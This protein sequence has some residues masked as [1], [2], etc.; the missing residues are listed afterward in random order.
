MSDEC[1]E[2]IA[3]VKGKYRQRCIGRDKQWPTCHSDKL[4]RL[5]LVERKKGEGYSANEQRGRK[6]K[7]TK[8]T[9]L[10]YGDLF[11]VESGK[12]PVRKVLVEGD[13]GIGKTTFCIAVSEDWANGK[14]FQQFELVLLLPLRI[15]AVASAGILPDLLKLLHSNP[16]LRDSVASY[17]EVEEGGRVLIIADGWDELSESNRQEGS[18]LYQLLFQLFPLI[19]VVVTSRPYASAPLCYLP[20]IDRFV[21]VRGFSEEHIVDYIQSEFASDQEKAGRLLEQLEDNPLIESVCSVPLNCTIVSYLWDT[22]EGALPTTMTQLYKKIIDNIA[23]RNMHKLDSSVLTFDSRDIPNDF[24]KSWWHLCELAFQALEKDQLVFSPKELKAK[25][26][27]LD[28]GIRCF[29][30]LQTVELVGF[31]ISFHF[32]HRTIQEYLAALHLARLEPDKQLEVFR[33]YNTKGFVMVWRFFFG[34]ND[35]NKTPNYIQQFFGCVADEGDDEISL[36]VCHCVFES[37]SVL[38]NNEVTQY[39]LHRDLYRIDF[40]TP[41]TAHDCAAILYV[42]ANISEC[43]DDILIYFSKNCDVKE[44]QIIELLDILASKEGKLQITYLDLSGSRLTVSS[45]QALESAVHRNLLHRLDLLELVISNTDTNVAQLTSLL[46][47][48]S[49]HCPHIG[50]LSFS[51]SNL[52]V[53]GV[54]VIS[55]IWDHST[56][57]LDLSSNHL[58]DE[59]MAILCEHLENVHVPE[60][61]LECNHIHVSG[62]SHLVDTICSGKAAITDELS[63]AGNPLGLEGTKAVGRMLSSSHCKVNDVLLFD[64]ELTTAGGSDSLNLGDTVSCEAVGQQLCQ[65]PQNSAVGYIDLSDNSFTVEGI[66]I[67]AGLMHLCPHISTVHTRNC[68]ITSDDLE[69]LLDRLAQL[70]SSSPSL[71]SK[72]VG[73]F[74][75]DNQIDNSGVSTLLNHLPS[76]FPRLGSV[77]LDNNQVNS[78]LMK[79]LNE[80]CRRRKEVSNSVLLVLISIEHENN[81]EPHCA[82]CRHS[83]T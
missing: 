36:S 35:F 73:W 22:L 53:P 23:L 3:S 49:V 37:H 63:L 40:G 47:T 71:C 14:L 62:V 83:Y 4:V 43:D 28:E 39:I 9:S 31:G 57:S 44:N 64:C 32:P 67:L 15:K 79:K 72:L 69:W 45:L 54:S 56:C 65:M 75:R 81:I 25:G 19:S 52:G 11:K 61:R 20:D 82:S 29:G 16:R 55:K 60:L 46:D 7:G 2:F 42:L 12:R 74:L 68:G 48:L 78:E 13:A 33:S 26:L 8:R 50:Y 5:E 77:D 24:Q 38:I 17:L 41:R 1:S 30:L 34:I 27:A 80:E 70:K 51:D 18:F 6:S 21:E 59:G 58:G 10:A 76:L 66:H